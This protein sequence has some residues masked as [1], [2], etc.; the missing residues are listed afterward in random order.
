MRTER[1]LIIELHNLT[2]GK[3]IKLTDKTMLKLLTVTGLG[4]AEYELDMRDN[5]LLDGSTVA[6]AKVEAREIV[7]QAE[8]YDYKLSPQN[9]ETLLHMFSPRHEYMLCVRRESVRR[10]IRARARL[11]NIDPENI[12]DF[13]TANIELVC[14]DPFFEDESDTTLQ[15][16][17]FE[18]LINF[19]LIFI[20]QGAG[21]TT[22]IQI[23]TDSITVNNDGDADF[24]IEFTAEVV[25]GNIVNPAVWCGDNYVR[26]LTTLHI[27]DTLK[28]DTRR[29]RKGIWLN[30]VK[31][32]QYDP[33][34]T[35][36]TLKPG[37]NQVSF[38]ADSGAEKAIGSITYSNRWFGV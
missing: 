31:F 34:S 23:V 22:A 5:A 13:Y 28:I 26:V 1:T 4:S 37:A 19:P 32:M 14:P 3:V 10:R 38:K 30:G 6:G 27:G 20:P 12:Y 16:R 35:W 24:G 17:L 29:G 36:F 8:L 15:F 11:F 25:G 18:P 2:L 9:R 33:T 21:L 7:M